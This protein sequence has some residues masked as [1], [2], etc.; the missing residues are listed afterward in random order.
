[1]ATKIL[2]VAAIVGAGLLWGAFAYRNTLAVR[3]F[4]PPRVAL[5]EAYGESDSELTFNHSTK[6]SPCLSMLITHSLCS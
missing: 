3:L 5:L 2:V 4:G 6:N 1:M